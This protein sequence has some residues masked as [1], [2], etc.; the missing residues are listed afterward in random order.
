MNAPLPLRL[1]LPIMLGLMQLIGLW[2]LLLGKLFDEWY[3]LLG[4]NYSIILRLTSAGWLKQNAPEAA[5]W[6][7]NRAGRQTVTAHQNLKRWRETLLLIGEREVNQSIKPW[8]KTLA[9]LRRKEM[10]PS[11]QSLWWVK[12]Q[13]TRAQNQS[14]LEM[15]MK[16]SQDHYHSIESTRNINHFVHLHMTVL[17]QINH[18]VTNAVLEFYT[19]NPVWSWETGGPVDS[20]SFSLACFHFPL[21]QSHQ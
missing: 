3:Q 20:M 7:G 11:F 8:I 21:P 4:F 15:T 2:L 1:R 9:S 14:S 19:T 18:F 6:A 16:I 10:I 17:L 13:E 5:C 12:E